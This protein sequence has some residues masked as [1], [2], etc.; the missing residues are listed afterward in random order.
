LILVGALEFLARSLPG[1]AGDTAEEL[2]VA[3]TGAAIYSFQ[4]ELDFFVT[5]RRLLLSFGLNP[6]TFEVIN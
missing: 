6:D 2:T 4:V 1:P 5:K 3:L